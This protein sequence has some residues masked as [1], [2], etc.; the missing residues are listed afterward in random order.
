MQHVSDMRQGTVIAGYQHAYTGRYLHFRA[1]YASTHRQVDWLAT[2]SYQGE[3]I[4]EL[5][6]AES[7]EGVVASPME[8]VKAAVA[9]AID[10]RDFFTATGPGSLNAL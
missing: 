10:R 4:D 5:S 2:V 9:A 6:G 7:L 1:V 8:V 3:I